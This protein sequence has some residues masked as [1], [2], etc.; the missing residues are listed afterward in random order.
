MLDLAIFYQEQKKIEQA[1]KYYE[2]SLK[3]DPQ[4]AAYNNLGII[5]K[6]RG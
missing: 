4:P 3:Y 6:N 2:L 1:I 5:F